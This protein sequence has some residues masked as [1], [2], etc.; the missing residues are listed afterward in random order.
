MTATYQDFMQIY[1]ENIRKNFFKFS[2][3]TKIM[4][5]SRD[6]TTQSVSILWDTMK[7]KLWCTSEWE[8]IIEKVLAVDLKNYWLKK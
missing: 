5:T 7:L 1:K 8:Q 2:F 4:L 6:F 3:H